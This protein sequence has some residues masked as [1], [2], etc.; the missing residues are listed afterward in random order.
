MY[1]DLKPIYWWPIM[2]T[3][4][5]HFV[6]K[7]HICALVKA[8]HQ[9][10]YG[11]LSLLNILEWKWEHITMD[12]ASL[13]ELAELYVKEIVSRHGVSLSILSDRDSR[14]VSNFWNSLQQNLGTRFAGPEIVQMTTEKVT[15]ALEKFKAAR[16]RL[17]IMSEVLNDQ[18]VVLDL[19]PEL[20]GIHNT[21]N[22][23]YMRKCKV[24]DEDQILPLKDLKSRLENSDIGK[25]SFGH[26]WGDLSISERSR[27]DLRKIGDPLSQEGTDLYEVNPVSGR[28]CQDLLFVQHSIKGH[29]RCV[30]IVMQLNQQER[31]SVDS[32]PIS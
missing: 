26:F 21:F 18:T 32:S 3:D 23:C 13:S 2:K 14:L 8:E 15:I 22:V 16:D 19:L 10:P 28:L 24:E 9:K 31:L 27:R 17:E 25:I 6:E 4:I 1:H 30:W 7:C 11:S 29:I 12:F 5:V 20:A